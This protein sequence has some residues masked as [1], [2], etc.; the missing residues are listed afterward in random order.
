MVFSWHAPYGP[1]YRSWMALAIVVPDRYRAGV[2][3]NLRLDPQDD[4]LLDAL[5]KELQLSK[6]DVTRL[7]IRE[8]AQRHGHRARV[9]AAT[10]E[11]LARWRGA[12]DVLAQ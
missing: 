7:A 12:L 11:M 9:S 3:M 10:D 4:A 6:Q 5:A 2:A 1:S 8:L